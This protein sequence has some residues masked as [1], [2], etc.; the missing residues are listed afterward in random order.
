MLNFGGVSALQYRTGNFYCSDH[1]GWKTSQSSKDGSGLHPPHQNSAEPL[2]FCK[3]LHSREPAEEPSHKAPKVLQNFGSQTRLSKWPNRYSHPVALHCCA[4]LSRCKFSRIW[5]GI[6]GE[7]NY[8]LFKGALAP[9]CPA[10]KRVLHFK[11]PPGRRRNTGGCRSYTV[12]CR[13]TVGHLA[14][15]TEPA[16]LLPS[17]STG[18]T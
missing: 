11:L 9:T 5:R 8:A 17:I 16:H 12:A 18:H 15:F 2:R 7:S 14:S 4:K 1:L 6:A 3:G 13:A 10:F